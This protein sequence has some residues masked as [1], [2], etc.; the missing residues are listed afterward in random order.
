MQVVQR[1]D[2][3]EQEPDMQHPAEALSQQMVLDF[4]AGFEMAKKRLETLWHEVCLPENMREDFWARYCTVVSASNYTRLV[5]EMT[6]VLMY[7]KAILR[8]LRG[9]WHREKYVSA[10]WKGDDK[11]ADPPRAVWKKLRDLTAECCEAIEMWQAMFTGNVFIYECKD[12]L[13]ALEG[14]V[15]WI[16][17]KVQPKE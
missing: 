14:E 11:S 4:E 8:A 10:N 13:N 16:D 12:Y 3:I 5:A 9:V 15:D 7:K 6:C 1:T 17:S 2:G